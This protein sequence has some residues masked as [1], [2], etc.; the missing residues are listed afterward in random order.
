M[1]FALMRLDHILA[2]ECLAILCQTFR[3]QL[4][5]KFLLACFN[6]LIMSSISSS[7]SNCR[8][9]G[10]LSDLIELAAVFQHSPLVFS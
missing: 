1:L 3:D 2:D 9:L 8:D 4:V 10:V 7:F 5:A 6:A